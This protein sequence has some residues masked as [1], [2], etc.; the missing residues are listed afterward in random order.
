[1]TKSL[2]DEQSLYD[3]IKNETYQQATEAPVEYELR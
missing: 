3:D 1:M 2:E